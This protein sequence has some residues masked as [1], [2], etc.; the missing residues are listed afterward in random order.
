MLDFVCAC[1]RVHPECACGMLLTGA[2]AVD[3]PFEPRC[4][5]TQVRCVCSSSS[6]TERRG[7]TATQD[8]DKRTRTTSSNP[9]RAP[10]VP[11]VL[12]PASQPRQSVSFCVLGPAGHLISGEGAHTRALA[13][14]ATGRSVFHRTFFQCVCV[15][16][17]VVGG[18]G[19]GR[20]LF[21][22][23]TT[24]LNSSARSSRSLASRNEISLWALVF[25][26]TN[27]STKN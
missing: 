9:S 10:R 22:T 14:C 1:M 4:E 18:G 23:T 15:R 11:R 2:P 7:A 19:G 25:S 13:A 24:G 21:S 6:N 16:E 8:T 3:A 17:S 5:C 27:I 26:W 12:G 20:M